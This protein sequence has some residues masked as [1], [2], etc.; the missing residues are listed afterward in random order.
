MPIFY[1]QKVRSN[2]YFFFLFREN[3]PLSQKFP[4]IVKTKTQIQFLHWT[5]EILQFIRF[6][7]LYEKIVTFVLD[8]EL[9]RENLILKFTRPF[10]K[11]RSA[12]SIG[13]KGFFSTSHLKWPSRPRLAFQWWCKIRKHFT[14]RCWNLE[15]ANPFFCIRIWRIKALY[16]KSLEIQ[17]GKKTLQ[18]HF[19]TKIGEIT[20][21][22]FQNLFY[23]NW[24]QNWHLFLL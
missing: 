22:K 8:T 3:R 21:K 1:L 9:G 18:F 20:T 19:L 7:F 2:I 13:V 15:M 5:K 6:F 10:Y 17:T 4:E 12:F 11:V 16:L 23:L 14:Y 24:R